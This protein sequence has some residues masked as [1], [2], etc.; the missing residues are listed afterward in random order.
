METLCCQAQGERENFPNKQKEGLR[1]QKKGDTTQLS[2]RR[3]HSCDYSAIVNYAATLYQIYVVLSWISFLSVPCLGPFIALESSD[4]SV[5]AG[6]HSE[7]KHPG[8]F[9]MQLPSRS[10]VKLNSHLSHY[11]SDRSQLE[12]P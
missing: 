12:L 8:V 1:E 10:S 2:R 11:A 7:A 9:V 6:Y 3:I 4:L 5:F